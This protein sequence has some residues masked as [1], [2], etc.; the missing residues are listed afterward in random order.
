MLGPNNPMSDP[1]VYARVVG[2]IRA[3]RLCPMPHYESGPTACEQMLDDALGIGWQTNIVV[4]TGRRRGSGHKAAYRIDVACA[5]VKIGVEVDGRSHGSPA[6]RADDAK[7]TSVLEGMGWRIV[8]VT[9]QRVRDD[10]E[11]VVTEIRA[12]VRVRQREDAQRE[13]EPMLLPM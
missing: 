7:K 8:R 4:R 2:A 3:K 1:Q 6:R 12:V 10:L 13:G 9:N 11:S 5:T